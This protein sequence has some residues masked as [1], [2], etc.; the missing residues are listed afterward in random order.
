MKYRLLI[1]LV[2]LNKGAIFTKCAT[3]QQGDVYSNKNQLFTEKEI[4]SL[5]AWFEPVAEE[6]TAATH[7]P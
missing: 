2:N 6:E 1:D 5:P 7:K 4:K 3:T